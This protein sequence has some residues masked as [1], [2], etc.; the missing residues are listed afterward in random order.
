MHTVA[1]F[2]L[3]VLPMQLQEPEMDLFTCMHGW[4]AMACLGF[5]AACSPA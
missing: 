1:S 3:P 4:C 5:S 2:E